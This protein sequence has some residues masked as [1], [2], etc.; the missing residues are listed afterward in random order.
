MITKNQA[1]RQNLQKI[2][3]IEDDI[4]EVEEIPLKKKPKNFIS[5]KGKEITENS[6]SEAT[7]PYK[8]TQKII[9]KE[10]EL[11]EIMEEGD[12]D[13]DD[14]KKFQALTGRQKKSDSKLPSNKNEGTLLLQSISKTINKQKAPES[15]DKKEKILSSITLN[16]SDGEEDKIK[17]NNKA[18][19]DSIKATKEKTQNIQIN[20]NNQIGVIEKGNKQAMKNQEIEFLSED[21][22]N[23]KIDLDANNLLGK[24]RKDYNKDNK[25]IITNNSNNQNIKIPSNKNIFD[26]IISGINSDK[27]VKKKPKNVK[28]NII[29]QKSDIDEDSSD[30]NYATPE[31]AVLGQLVDE[32]G[33]EKILDSL[34][35]LKLNQKNKLESCLQGLK[36]SCTD[37]KINFIL[38]KTLFSYFEKKIN[39]KIQA[40][41]EQKISTSPKKSPL[42][43]TINEN[44]NIEDVLPSNKNKRI[45]PININE[46]NEK[47]CKKIEEKINTEEKP[48]DKGITNPPPNNSNEGMKSNDRKMISVGSH[49]HKNEEG[50]IFR[51]QITNLD[52]KGNAIFKCYDDKCTGTGIYELETMKFTVV[53]D[54]N[55]KHS[56][57][58]YIVDKDGDEVFNKLMEKG[59]FNAQVFKENGKKNIQIY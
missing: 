45:L 47:K 3:Q 41:Q 27:K 56:E 52:G 1:K 12:Q 58:E 17:N 31:L 33:F 43:K 10:D 20:Q 40:S 14:K 32:Y 13:M 6:S 8:K 59:K 24:K 57:H 44:N 29:P 21:S 5:Q 55:L 9:N 48:R 2:A 19:N 49:Y 30:K 11:I 26:E 16:E 36:D 25:P 4:I 51:Y 34:C 39:E 28:N 22:E 35:K 38:F 46:E 42:Q 53:K 50:K 18:I 23:E 7:T 54:H 15:S 37:N